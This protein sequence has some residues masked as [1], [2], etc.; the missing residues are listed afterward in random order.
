MFLIFILLLLFFLSLF[1]FSDVKKISHSFFFFLGKIKRN[2][3]RKESRMNRKR[4]KIYFHLY[5]FTFTFF[6]CFVLSKIFCLVQVF[7]S[8]QIIIF[9]FRIFLVSFSRISLFLDH[10]YHKKT[11]LEK[12]FFFFNLVK[13]IKC[14]R[15]FVAG[16]EVL[17]PVSRQL[18]CYAEELPIAILGFF[19]QYDV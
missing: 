2:D 10:F 15:F 19:E 1:F 17:D 13:F 18:T 8:E 9:L 6:S 14:Y 3:H 4:K 5:S 11:V 7:L 16:G 12:K